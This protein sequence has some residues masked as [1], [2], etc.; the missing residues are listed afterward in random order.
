MT[1]KS[2]KPANTT[3][4]PAEA[5]KATATTKPTQP[6]PGP[7]AGLPEGTHEVA[8]SAIVRDPNY[9]ARMKGTDPLL[10]NSYATAIKAGSEF[11]PVTLARVKGHALLVA[12]WHRVAA[13]ERAG[14]DQIKAEI[15]DCTAAGA[16]WLAASSNLSHGRPPSRADKRFA[17]TA[18]IK[19][20]KHIQP[21]TGGAYLTYAEIAKELHGIA[22]PTTI[23]NWMRKDFPRIAQ[24]MGH[25]GVDTTR[26]G[27][28]TDTE[29]GYFRAALAAV[30]E[31][32]AQMRAV[33]SLDRRT[34]VCEAVEALRNALLDSTGDEFDTPI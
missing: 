8:I 13:H 24:K 25:E 17:F 19:A 28:T 14:R 32:E 30:R 26:P 22:T 23:W 10:V 4:R 27:T 33:K 9:Q 34:E 11:P 2:S 20:R 7:L 31:V 3:T 18:F 6:K 12:G 21:G 15:V 5:V 16:M 29:A 1:K